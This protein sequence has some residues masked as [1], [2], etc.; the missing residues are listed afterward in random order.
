MIHLAPRLPVDRNGARSGCSWHGIDAI[1]GITMRWVP[2]PPG[3]WSPGPYKTTERL[4]KVTC[5]ECRGV[6][7]DGLLESGVVVMR[8]AF[9][10]WAIYG[11]GRNRGEVYAPDTGPVR[12]MNDIF[13]EVYGNRLAELFDFNISLASQWFTRD[14]TA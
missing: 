13:K 12:T 2:A 7:L 1:C 5:P 10:C 11:D 4:K 3:V 14:N 6:V 8:G 9:C